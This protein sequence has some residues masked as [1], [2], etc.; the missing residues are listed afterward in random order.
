MLSAQWVYREVRNICL[1]MAVFFSAVVWVDCKCPP[2]VAWVLGQETG[3][4]WEVKV[5]GLFRVPIFRRFAEG[6]HRKRMM[7]V[8][9]MA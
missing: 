4:S 2:T 1:A 7:P 5:G 9:A 8:L 6:T 3:R